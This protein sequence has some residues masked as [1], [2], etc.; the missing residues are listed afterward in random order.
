MIFSSVSFRLEISSNLVRAKSRAASTAILCSSHTE[1][2]QAASERSASAEVASNASVSV[3]SNA[4][5]SIRTARSLSCNVRRVCLLSRNICF[6]FSLSL[7]SSPFSISSCS[8]CSRMLSAPRFISLM[9]DHLPGLEFF[10]L[11][12]PDVHDY[13]LQLRLN[14]R[15][16]NFRHGSPILSNFKLQFQ[17]FELVDERSGV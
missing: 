7:C 1:I 5:V 3:A 9:I 10:F 14:L 4:S 16:N 13:S 17:P 15:N 11:F 2:R 8:N 12:G 6:I